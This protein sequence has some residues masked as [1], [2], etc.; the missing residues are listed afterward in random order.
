MTAED[1]M[2]HAKQDGVDVYIVLVSGLFADK[3]VLLAVTKQ[4]FMHHFSHLDKDAKVDFAHI[5]EDGDIVID[6]HHIAG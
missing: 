2:N 3:W 1:F 6:P 4:S 5:D